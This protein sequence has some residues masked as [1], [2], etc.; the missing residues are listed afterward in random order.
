MGVVLCLTTV[1]EM[2]L[3]F[4]TAGVVWK[5]GMFAE[6]VTQRQLLLQNKVRS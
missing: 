2:V 3:S 5:L 6:L 1:E 4:N